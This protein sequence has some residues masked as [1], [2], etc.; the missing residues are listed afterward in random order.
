MSAPGLAL[1]CIGGYWGVP[2][3]GKKWQSMDLEVSTTSP[4]TQ[5]PLV[6]SY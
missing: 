1:E 3:K 2:E 5:D 6:T 4:L